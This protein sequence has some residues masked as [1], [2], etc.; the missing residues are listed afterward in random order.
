[1]TFQLAQVNIA[2]LTAPLDDPALAGFVAAL[3]PVNAAADQAPGFVWRLQ[4]EDGNATAIQAFA[5]D[6]AGSAAVIVN[7]SVWS[8]VEHLAAFVFGERHRQVLRRRREWFHRMR[9]AYMACWW[10]PAGHLPST[11][12]A[13]ARVRY[14]RSHGSTPRAFTLRDSYPAPGNSAGDRPAAGRDE[15]FCPA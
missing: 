13:E 12:E 8:D 10:V 14:L 11:G 9:E 7:L 3:D 15:W 5:W 1:M 6:A 2:R 4:T